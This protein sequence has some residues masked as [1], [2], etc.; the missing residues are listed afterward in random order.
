M[1]RVSLMPQPSIMVLPVTFCHC[2]ARAF[3]GRHAPACITHRCEEVQ[4]A[5]LGVCSSALN[6]VF[7]AGSM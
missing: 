2:L 7:T 5:E 4:C 1:A 6:S 3:A